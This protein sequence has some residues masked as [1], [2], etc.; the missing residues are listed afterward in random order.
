MHL[1]SVVATEQYHTR[2]ANITEVT[3][4]FGHI[5]AL[6]SDLPEAAV[7]HHLVIRHAGH[8]GWLRI[9]VLL[10]P[11]Q[12]IELRGRDAI[13]FVKRR[14]RPRPAS[15]RPFAAAQAE[16]VTGIK[17]GGKAKATVRG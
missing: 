8:H 13:R 9:E 7:G 5:A 14:E 4:R 3:H 11:R 1:V 16:K 15:E 2:E 10:E 6:N 12:T 17:T